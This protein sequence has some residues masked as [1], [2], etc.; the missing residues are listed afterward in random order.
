MLEPVLEPVLVAEPAEPASVESA[1]SAEAYTVVGSLADRLEVD[2]DC[3]MRI[4]A[5][6]PALPVVR[7]PFD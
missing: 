2:S 1:V 7:T 6:S 3:F 5:V 4:S